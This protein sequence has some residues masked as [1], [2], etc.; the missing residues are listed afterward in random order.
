MQSNFTFTMVDIPF[1]FPLAVLEW[2]KSNLNVLQLAASEN[3]VLAGAGGVAIVALV[4]RYLLASKK[5]RYISDLSKVG[6]EVGKTTVTEAMGNE[7]YDI[8]VAGGGMYV[9]SSR[10]ANHSLLAVLRNCR[11]RFGRKVE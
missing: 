4:L 7:E 2:L 3:R 10:D 11:M 6:R 9:V 5:S 8:I 1:D